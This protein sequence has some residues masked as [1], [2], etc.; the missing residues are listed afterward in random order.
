MFKKKDKIE[1]EVDIVEIYKCLHA[2]GKSTL[3]TVVMVDKNNE[4]I[5]STLSTNFPEKGSKA[6]LTAKVSETGVGTHH[7][8]KT[9]YNVTNCKF[10]K[11]E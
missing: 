7:W 1:V 5:W 4:Y 8:D 3:N 9:A 10:K 2:D 6:K 11:A